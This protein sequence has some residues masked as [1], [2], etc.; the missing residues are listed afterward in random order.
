MAVTSNDR[1]LYQQV[2]GK[3][4]RLWSSVERRFEM[5]L[6]GR[7][8]VGKLVLDGGKHWGGDGGEAR[9]VTR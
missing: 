2:R 5:D 9:V 4:A 3:T 1:C 7:E 6:K 8:C